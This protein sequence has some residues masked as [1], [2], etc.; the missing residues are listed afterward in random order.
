MVT[1]CY[2]EELKETQSQFKVN[3]VVYDLQQS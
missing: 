2:A 1:Y 3:N